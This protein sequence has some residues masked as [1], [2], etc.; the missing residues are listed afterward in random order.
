MSLLELLPQDLFNRVALALDVAD[1][2]SL[3]LVSRRVCALAR[4]SQLWLDRIG[5]DFGDRALIVDLLAEAGLDIAERV[6]ARSDLA[7]WRP[8]LPAQ[9]TPPAYGL[10]CYRARYSRVFPASEDERLRLVRRFEAEID[11][12]KL[13]LRDEQQATDEV[14]AE[15]ACRLVLVQ[16]YF[17][18]SVECYYL[19]ALLCFLRG[20]LRPTLSFVAIGKGL[21]SDFEPLQELASE[22]QAAADC[23][24]GVGDEAPLLDPTCAGPSRQLD[25]ALRIIFQKLDRDRDGVLN[26]AE[27]KA[28]I[29]ITNAQAA[30]N[31]TVRQVIEAFGG[32]VRAS[33]GRQVTGWSFD[34]LVGFYMAQTMQDPKETRQDIAKFGFDPHTLC[35]I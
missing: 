2:A 13:L 32:Q 7:A 6:D 25:A 5:S 15:A 23:V 31:A 4:C 20:A 21:S 18:A 29:K 33:S 35:R 30:T 16:E 1:H 19:W 34:S 17:P 28:M 27:L 3:A 22:A 14:A 24:F 12:V 11:Q 10:Q 8:L 9:P 26:M